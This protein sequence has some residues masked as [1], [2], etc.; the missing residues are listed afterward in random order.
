M[1]ISTKHYDQ[2]EINENVPCTFWKKKSY[3]YFS[4]N[5]Q[6]KSRLEVLVINER[7]TYMI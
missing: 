4:E 5:V 2:D 1:T 6:G 7:T 3:N